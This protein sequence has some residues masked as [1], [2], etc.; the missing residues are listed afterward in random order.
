MNEFLRSQ[1]EAWR[2]LKLRVRNGYRRLVAQ[3][4]CP[5]HRFGAGG[6][7]VL[8]LEGSQQCRERRSSQVTG[9]S[10]W[11]DALPSPV[12]A[13][14]SSILYRARQIPLALTRIHYANTG[15]RLLSAL[16]TP[17]SCDKRVPSLAR[18]SQSAPCDQSGPWSGLGT[19]QRQAPAC[20]PF[21]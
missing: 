12:S 17:F 6:D 7:F 13:F 18:P 16:P 15:P 20:M 2:A 10:G 11:E 5:A 4:D 21:R 8:Y 19:L 3:P 1:A 9:P 14:Y